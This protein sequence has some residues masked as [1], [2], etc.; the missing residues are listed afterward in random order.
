MKNILTLVLIM[1]SF[2]L[3]AKRIIEGYGQ[4]KPVENPSFQ[5]PKNVK[6]V[7]DVYISNDDNEEFNKGINTVARYL[8][9]HFDA[10]LKKKNINAALVIHGAAGKDIL[11][12]KAYNKRYITDN[13]NIELL[14]KLHDSGVQIIVCGQTVKFRGYESSE[15][16]DFIDIS[17][18]AITALISLQS[19]GYQI[20]NFN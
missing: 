20:I 11:T 6:A 12:N 9:M 17:L 3:Y 7:F 18:S 14:K 8:N 16:L 2:N 19:D 5:T 13:P 15:I 4:F 1:T 10:G